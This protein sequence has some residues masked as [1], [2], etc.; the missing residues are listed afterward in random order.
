[1]KERLA[2]IVDR[3]WRSR[4]GSCSAIADLIHGRQLAELEPYR[5]ELWSLCFRALDD[6]K[7]SVRVA[8]FGTCKGLTNF[9][10]KYSDADNA[11]FKDSAKVLNVVVP[12]LLTMGVGSMSEDVRNFSL[13]TLL[14]TCDRGGPLLKTHATDIMMTLLEGLSS[15]EPQVMSENFN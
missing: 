6:I 2:C 10:L 5:Q 7:E 14:K 3:Q 8:A 13:K 15:S 4:E 12:F 9:T 11:S 1:M